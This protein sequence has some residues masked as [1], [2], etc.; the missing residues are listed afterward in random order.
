MSESERDLDELRALARSAGVDADA[1]TELLD[2]PPAA[3][4]DRIASEVDRG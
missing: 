2:E 1:P 4:W 3:I